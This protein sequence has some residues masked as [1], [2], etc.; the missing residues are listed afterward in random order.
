MINI[1]LD[2]TGSMSVMGKNSGSV[3]VVKAIQDYCEVHNI[4][5]SLFKIDG[6]NIDDL[7]SLAFNDKISINNLDAFSNTIL[8]SDGL[9]ECNRED[10]FDISL[11]IGI[12]SDDMNLKKISKVSFESE[13]IIKAIE[14]LIFQNNINITK[15]EDEWS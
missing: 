12:D 11:S 3:Y 14:Y 10:T 13:N 8:V 2:T 6:N 9:L 7:F 4:K 5:T 15:D 1:F